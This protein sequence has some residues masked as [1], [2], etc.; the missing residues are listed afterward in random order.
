MPR[1]TEPRR[2]PRRQ[3]H[4]QGRRLHDQRRRRRGP[5]SPPRS[6]ASTSSSPAKRPPSSRRRSSIPLGTAS[7]VSVRSFAEA[8]MK[9]YDEPRNTATKARYA[10]LCSPRRRQARLRS[11]RIRSPG[12]ATSCLGG[13][14]P[15]DVDQ[16][17]H[18][19]NPRRHAA[20]ARRGWC[21]A[22]H[23]RAAREVEGRAAYLLPAEAERL[24]ARR[25]AA[26]ASR[27]S[28]SCSP[29]APGSARRSISTGMTARS[30]SPGDR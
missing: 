15:S 8:L 9:Y 22:P 27:S 12:C 26:C 18:Q 5:C 24:I 7:V 19:P 17:D 16:R 21:T 1:P 23:F 11:T 25:G 6:K 13:S 20:G 2:R 4:R 3:N 14:S 29:P 10:A 30:T 28:C